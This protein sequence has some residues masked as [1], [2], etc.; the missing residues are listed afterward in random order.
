MKIEGAGLILDVY[1]I[2]MRLLRGPPDTLDQ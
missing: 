1:K 2:S